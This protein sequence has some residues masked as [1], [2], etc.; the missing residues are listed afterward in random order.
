MKNNYSAYTEKIMYIGIFT[1]VYTII[2]SL[3]SMYT[4]VRVSKMRRA[5]L[6]YL[7]IIAYR[8]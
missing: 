3:Y 5:D 1:V 4:S 6:L 8:A 2:Y 7:R